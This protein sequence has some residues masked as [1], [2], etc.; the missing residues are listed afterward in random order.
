MFTHKSSRKLVVGSLLWLVV[1]IGGMAH[2]SERP[3]AAEPADEITKLLL[4]RARAAEK[5]YRDEFAGLTQ[6]RRMGNTL[7]PVTRGPED[8]YLWS[9]RWLKAQQQLS[10]KPEDQAAALQEH[11]KRMTELKE[12]VNKLSR[13]LLPRFKEDEV[14]VYRLEAELWLA[15]AKRN[16][17]NARLIRPQ[18]RAIAGAIG[19][20]SFV[21]AYERTA[22]HAKVAGYIEKWN[23][24]IGDKVKKG[25]VLATLFAPELRE[26]WQSKK[27]KVKLAQQQVEQAKK[28]VET[29]QAV[30]K[31]AEANLAETKSILN[32]REA[33]VERWNAEIKRLRREAERGIVDPQVIQESEIQLKASMAA[34]DAAKA[35]VVKAEAELLAKRTTEAEVE[36]TVKAA[37]VKRDLAESEAKRLEIRVG[38]LTL[39]APYDG[40][41][42]ARNVN[43]W[44]FVSPGKGPPLYVIER[45]DIVRVIVHVPERDAL[46]VRLGTKASVHIPGYQD[47]PIPA[48]VTRTSWAL[49]PRSRTLRAEIDLPNPKDAILPGFYAYGKVF[50]KRSDCWALPL[51]AL[52]HRGGKTFYWAYDEGRAVRMEVQTGLRDGKWIEVV[53]RRSLGSREDKDWEPIEGTEEVILGEL[54]RLSDGKPVSLVDPKS[55]P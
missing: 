13:D 11:L 6:T 3:E 10:P 2:A 20:P 18:Q 55:S 45:V 24:D 16:R 39:T 43:T 1:A 28:A 51:G 49:D 25:D 17:L 26:E 14:E 53:N 5:A 42:T 12:T 44:D 34:R 7:V 32:R 40:I 38:Y 54:S 29:A 48:T 52:D 37:E 47:K 36:L 27:A 31:S 8:V 4:A 23:V 19:Q 33:E 35:A 41:I 9:V 15:K 50:L 46:M 21:E 30:I 22:I